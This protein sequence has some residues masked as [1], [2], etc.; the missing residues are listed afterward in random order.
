MSQQVARVQRRLSPSTIWHVRRYQWVCED[1][2]YISVIMIPMN[3]TTSITSCRGI[4]R[5]CYHAELMRVSSQVQ[6]NV[7]RQYQ[8]VV[9]RA[10]QRDIRSWNAFVSQSSPGWK[11]RPVSVD[12]FGNHFTLFSEIPVL[13]PVES[14]RTRGS[15]GLCGETETKC[16]VGTR[17]A[18]LFTM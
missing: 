7:C 2:M 11:A 3:F 1:L 10:N 9:V 14:L 13:C 18:R 8:P 4:R 17:Q 16:A 6:S 5:D 15:L 12:K